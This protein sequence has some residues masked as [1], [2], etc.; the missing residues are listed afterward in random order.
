MWRWAT[1]LGKS[2]RPVIAH[3]SL[4]PTNTIT[5]HTCV[6][7]CVLQSDVY[8]QL[9]YHETVPCSSK[10]L[11]LPGWMTD[12]HL[13]RRRPQQV[14]AT[15]KSAR[16]VADRQPAQAS[17]KVRTLSAKQAALAAAAKRRQDCTYDASPTDRR[18]RRSVAATLWPRHS[19]FSVHSC[20]LSVSSL[21]PS[22]PAV[23]NCR[24][25]NGSAQS[26]PYWSN[27]PFL[28]FDIR[29]LWRSVLSARARKCQKLKMVG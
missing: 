16:V 18:N 17:R 25:S 8:S 20:H 14:A 24:C 1:T 11:Q 5:H 4:N 13:L 21:T 29:A 7:V 28:I 27:L 12:G 9:P 26:A 3:L 19:A 2:A 22:T 6:C 23:P 15:P 10:D